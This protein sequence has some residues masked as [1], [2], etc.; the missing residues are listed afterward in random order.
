MKTLIV[1]EGKTDIDFLSTFLDCDFYSVNGSAVSDKDIDFIKEYL[2]KGEVV[3]LTDPDFPGLKIRNYLNEKIPGLKNA[4]VRKE[5]S[6]KHNKVGVA[7]STVDEVKS[8]LQ[9]A[10]V[11][12]SKG[13]DYNTITMS[14]LIEL[15]LAGNQNSFKLRK[16][17][18]ENL[19]IGFSNCKT[20]LKKLNML[21]ITK[22]ELEE[23]V[24]M[25]NKDEI[26]DYFK[27][28]NSHAKKELGQNFLVNQS[29]ASSIVNLLD[30]NEE[31]NVL[32]IGP[33]LGALTGFVF[34]KKYASYEV[35]EYD[36]KFVEFL[37][38][39]FD[40]KKIKITK[41]NILKIKEISANKIIGNLPYYITS[42]IILKMVLEDEKL[43]KAVFMVQKEC[44]K[45][46]V[47]KSGKDYNALNVL[48][49]YLFDIK[50]ELIVD[51]GNFFPVPNVDS[52]VFSLTKK[53]E[54]NMDF[55]RFLFKVS[56]ISFQNRRKT[57][58]NNLSSLVANKE[59][60]LEVFNK[61]NILPTKR[62]EELTVQDFERLS[63]E[64]LKII[65]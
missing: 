39:S 34:D 20:L 41:N 51:R 17:V 28:V 32:E 40:E 8:A 50:Q 43:T 56:K 2:K 23:V 16:K 21:E 25:L 63:M 55:A 30:I 4:F 10:K 65:N 49:A 24:K 53:Q 61:A 12:S 5:N 26:I 1:V 33:G 57:L 19:H 31:D 14:D 37:T 7:E 48:L 29:I 35:V 38:R 27:L 58:Q 64:L 60:L 47:A 62:A 36:Q 59:S 9:N 44:Y 42:E 15:G 3:I 11:F 13:T 46:I 22:E 45:R 18:S 6:I 54:K 52:L